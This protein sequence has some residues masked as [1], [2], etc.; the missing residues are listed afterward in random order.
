MHGGGGLDAATANL[1]WETTAGQMSHELVAA[2]RAPCRVS[3]PPREVEGA[4]RG[5]R[6]AVNQEVREAGLSA[7]GSLV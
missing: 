1:S 2:L 3:L 4:T 5:V 7:R 6:V